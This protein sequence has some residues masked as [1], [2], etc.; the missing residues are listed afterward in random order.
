MGGGQFKF[1]TPS[2]TQHLKVQGF[3]K[4]KEHFLSLKDVKY[5]TSRQ[6]AGEVNRSKGRNTKK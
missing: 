3:L 4:V 6:R 1:H 5:L 2:Q